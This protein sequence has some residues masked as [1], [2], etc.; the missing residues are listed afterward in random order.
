MKSPFFVFLY[1]LCT[2]ISLIGRLIFLGKR[3]MDMIMLALHN[4]REREEEE[5]IA[6]FAEADPRFQFESTKIMEGNVAAV[7]VFEW[8]G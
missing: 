3:S 5:W 7:L 2:C 6:L 4:S 8:K 1:R